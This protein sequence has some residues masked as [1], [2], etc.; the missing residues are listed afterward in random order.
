MRQ[1]DI[2]ANLQMCIDRI[3]N[4]FHFN[5]DQ[6]DSWYNLTP[7]SVH[8]DRTAVF[9]PKDV[10]PMAVQSFPGSQ[11][12]G[13]YT[14][15]ELSS[16]WD[17]IL[18]SAVSKNALKKFSQKLIVFS[19]NHK[20]PD[21]F[22]YS[23]PR[24]DFYVNNMISP[25]YFKD[26]FMDRFGQ[27]AKVLEHSGIYVSVFLVFK[28][29][30]DVAVKVIRHLEITKRTGAALEFGRILLTASNNFFLTSSLTSMY[31]PLSP[32]L[33]AGEEESKTLCNAEELKDMRDLLGK[34][35][36]TSNPFGVR[37]NLTKV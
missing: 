2:A 33:A 22:P 25:V 11:D 36:S 24:T 31:D 26:R 28:L 30:T 5:T 23:L 32:T 18:V 1:T 7:G 27:V 6:E 14:S 17:R 10:S 4:L 15:I 8:Q 21:S 13:M 34:K 19:K 29:I 20:N 9:G 16:F 12:A 37:R 35:R 3:R